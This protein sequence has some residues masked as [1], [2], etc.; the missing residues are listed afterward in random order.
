MS[1]SGYLTAEISA[2]AVRSNLERIRAQLSSATELCPVVKSDAYGLGLELL[3]PVVAPLAD[4]LAVATP[5][6]ALTLRRLGWRGP[7]LG[8]F[9]VA[10]HPDAPAVVRELVAAGVTL[11]V[12]APAEAELL[13][14]ALAPGATA[15]VHLKLDTGMARSGVWHRD[16]AAAAAAIRAARL[17]LSGLYTHLATAGE[18]DSS[19]AR[20]QLDRFRR[21]AAAVGGDGVCLHVAN[22]AALFALPDSHLDLV[23]PGLAIY[24]YRGSDDGPS[25]APCLRLTARLMQIKTVPAGT[26]T[27][28]GL[29]HTFER[30]SR[31]GLVAIGY[32]DGYPWA[33][34]NRAVMRLGGRPA[35]VRGRI[36]MDQTVIDLTELPSAAVGD[37][38]EVIAAQPAAPNSVE[39]LARLAGS[40]PY[41]LL[42]RLGPRAERVLTD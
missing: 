4:R 8:F 2:G 42:C 18:P 14:G 37:E 1:P 23:R 38:V 21:A 27:G 16:A 7:V 36:S 20:R 29:E 24:G 12:T 39:A 33:L 34:G 32:A 15:E 9:S 25:L 31:I 26:A 28:Y 30:R 3:L 41:E 10:G 19:F 17:R 5:A 11:S 13:A 22:S 40:V 35:P 6:E